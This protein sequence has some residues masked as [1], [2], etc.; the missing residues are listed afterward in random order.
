MQPRRVR[1]VPAA[2]NRR[3]RLH[4]RRHGHRPPGRRRSHP[5]V[6]AHPSPRAE[7]PPCD[8]L[9]RGGIG[10][11]VEEQ[12]RRPR[13]P[14]P[15]LLRD[16]VPGEG[17]VADRRGGRAGQ[18]EM[19]KVLFAVELELSGEEDGERPGG[20]RGGAQ[21]GEYGLRLQRIG[22]FDDVRGVGAGQHGGS[23]GGEDG[24]HGRR[25]HETALA[26]GRG[27]K[28]QRGPGGR[29]GRSGR[30]GRTQRIRRMQR[31]RCPGH[32]VPPLTSVTPSRRRMPRQH[33]NRCD[34][35]GGSAVR[36]WP[37][38]DGLYLTRG[39]PHAPR[40]PSCRR[41]D[42]H[43]CAAECRPVRTPPAA[44]DRRCADRR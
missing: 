28:Q 32:W 20:H 12:G 34:C 2:Q 5:P 24:Q 29:A 14:Q 7:L 1:P 36:L 37:P 35:E 43:H 4:V 23:D 42:G 6:H 38:M 8:V 19:R 15:Q 41:R 33:R 44:P 27:G 10:V 18:G 40:T 25:V 39:Q 11:Q 13:R 26:H 31:T 21:P 3:D 30:A 17:G 16:P 22:E 9:P